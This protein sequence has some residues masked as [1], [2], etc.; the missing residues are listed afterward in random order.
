ME[1]QR[2]PYEN[3]KVIHSIYNEGYE[4]PGWTLLP[5][6]WEQ[7]EFDKTRVYYH[8]DDSIEDVRRLMIERVPC[9]G[10]AKLDA[11]DD[12]RPRGFYNTE[13]MREAF[14]WGNTGAYTLST[15]ERLMPNIAV[16]CRA[17]VSTKLGMR[18]THVLNLIGYELQ[19]PDTLDA[20][21]FFRELD[22]EKRLAGIVAAYRRMWEL[23]LGAVRD[24]KEAGAGAD[25]DKMRVMNIGGAAF[26]GEYYERFA[27]DIFEPA[28]LPLA[29]EFEA[30]GV[31]V[32]GY[33]R[34]RKRFVGGLIPGCLDKEEE[35]VEGTLYLNAW[36]PF[37]LI[38][39]G[40]AGDASLDGAWGSCSNMAVLG[41][42]PT[43]PVMKFVAV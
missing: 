37:T 30:L 36:D 20:R 41:W 15:P 27:E 12:N 14:P 4:F 22:V 38:G 31:R 2:T 43:N 39:N 9:F 8:A 13:K 19:E 28:F 29:G 35:D 21:H 7:H 1:E 18:Q 11:D 34:K 24:L 32:R 23:A 10:T 25:F 33:D 40:N 5:E 6:F 3:A 17:L 26:A 42:L 16:Y